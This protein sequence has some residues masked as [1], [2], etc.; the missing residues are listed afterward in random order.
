MSKR[1]RWILVTVVALALLALVGRGFMARKNTAAAPATAASAASAAATQSL[2]LAAGDIATVGQAE[3]VGLLSVNG[4]LRAVQSA[5][6]KAKVAAELKSLSVR[7]GDRVSA[8]QLI[9]QL[10]A[11]EVRLRLKQAED[12]AAAAQSQLDIAQRT[13]DNNKALVNQGFI[14]R[15]ALETSVSSASG[16]QSSLQAAQAAAAIARKAVADSEVRAPIAGLVSQRLVQPG[17]RVSVDGRI[18]EIVDLSRIELEAAVAPED[19]VQLRVGQMARVEIDGLA[20]PIAAKVVRINPAAQAGTR[21]VSA[22]LELQAG[23]HMAGL[24]QGLFARGAVELQRRQALVVPATAVR[25]DQA[26]PYVL[27][28]VDGVAKSMPVTLGLRGDARIGSAVEPAVE[29]TAGV[30]AGTTVLRG[31]VGS[32]REGTR[33]SLPGRTAPAAAPALTTA[34]PPSAASR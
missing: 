5:V 18:V 27:A 23:P 4:G 7:E 20:A 2:E 30:S 3:L 10:D 14:S 17:E 12:Q 26:K 21:T 13:L 11:T 8:G 9:G 31:T 33:L 24:R 1:T 19:V 22:Y 16:A 6:V 15:T 28:V 29:V 32:L 34:A 25:F